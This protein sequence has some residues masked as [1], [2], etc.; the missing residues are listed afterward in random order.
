MENWSK[1]LPNNEQK[2]HIHSN[3]QHAIRVSVLHP[4][5]MTQ[6][7]RMGPAHQLNKSKD[8]EAMLQ[9]RHCENSINMKQPST[10]IPAS[11]KG[12]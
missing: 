9:V 7:E 12:I 4:L 5:C 3:I 2:I 6:G 8:Q 10:P 11:T 1:V